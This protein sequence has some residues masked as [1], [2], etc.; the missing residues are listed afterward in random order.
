VKVAKR[1][2]AF[3]IYVFPSQ[4]VESHSHEIPSQY[5]EFKDVFEKRN[6]NTLHKHRPYDC[7]I[8][9]VEGTQLSF[10]PIYKLSQVVLVILREYIDGGKKKLNKSSFDNPSFQ[11]MPLSSLSKR[12]MAFCEYVLIIIDPPS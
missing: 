6:V 7:T 2:N 9:L 10:R 4:D 3:F 8:H 1:R 11:L 5:Q 12:K